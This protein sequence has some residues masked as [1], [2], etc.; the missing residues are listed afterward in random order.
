MAASKDW[1]GDATLTAE[2]TQVGAFP[3]D[4]T[5]RDAALVVTLPPGAYS[6]QVTGQEGTSGIA[7]VEIYELP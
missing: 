2:F 6:A 7:L 5:S 3:L 1:G 4:A